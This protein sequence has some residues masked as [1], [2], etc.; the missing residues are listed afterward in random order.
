MTYLQNRGEDGLCGEGGKGRKQKEGVLSDETAPGGG[1]NWDSWSGDLKVN[2]LPSWVKR[3]PN[4]F[5]FN[6]ADD[7]L[8]TSK[9]NVQ[10]VRYSLKRVECSQS[11]EWVNGFSIADTAI[12][13]PFC[14][15]LTTLLTLAVD[16]LNFLRAFCYYSI[17]I[18]SWLTIVVVVRI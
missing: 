18:C 2:S 15:G 13:D 7:Y 1:K 5:R 8:T 4:Q 12:T 10:M 9:N 11:C 3:R 14:R 16:K 17:P 6:N